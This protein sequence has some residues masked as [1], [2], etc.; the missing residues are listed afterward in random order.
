[1]QQCIGTWRFSLPDCLMRKKRGAGL[2]SDPPPPLCGSAP[3]LPPR[4]LLGSSA[5]T[6]DN[7]NGGL[8]VVGSYV[9]KTTA[10]VKA[11]ASLKGMEKVEV[12]VRDLLDDTQ[13]TAAV[14]TAVE[15]V[16][17]MLGSG[18]DT[19]LFTSRALVTDADAGV[20]LD[21]GRRVSE[22]LISIVQKI[23]CQP[24][25]LVAKGGIT[26]SDIATRGLE[27]KRAMIMGQVLPGVPV[28][29]LGEETRWPGMAYIVFP[30]NVGGDDAL[31]VVRE[32]LS[33]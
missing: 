33:K 25:Y 6:V 28:W 7:Q 14:S 24:R 13:Q 26:S 1:M 23:D 20:S 5:L 9:P 11:L 16:N 8:F 2:S 4:D 12:N 32:R 18:Q 3:E 21:I 19:V 17:R 31:A 15:R 22:S 27:V 10:Q 30:G 29:Q